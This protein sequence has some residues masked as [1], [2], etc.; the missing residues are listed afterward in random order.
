MLPT[1]G[2]RQV[3]RSLRERAETWIVDSTELT[4]LIRLWDELLVAVCANEHDELPWPVRDTAT[5]L[6]NPADG[7]AIAE[8]EARLGVALPPSYRSFLLLSDGAWA[9][10]GWGL[11]GHR[12]ALDTGVELQ[13]L[14]GILMQNTTPD[15]LAAATHALITMGAEQAG[16]AVEVL[17]ASPDEDLRTLSTI[18]QRKS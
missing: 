11:T 10:P 14:F 3:L 9:Q 18:W 7:A 4:D 17:R 1:S 8:L 6:R 15:V 16:L 5:V 12:R 13:G 2:S